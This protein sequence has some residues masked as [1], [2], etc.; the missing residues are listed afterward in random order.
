MEVISKLRLIEPVALEGVR[1][2]R[3]SSHLFKESIIK[4]T[5]FLVALSI[6]LAASSAFAEGAE[7]FI[8]QN[9]TTVTSGAVSRAQVQQD[10]VAAQRSGEL[11][12]IGAEAGYD[13]TAPHAVGAR[14]RAEVQ[15]EA[16]AL[17]HSPNQNLDP[18]AFVNSQIP[19]SLSTS[20]TPARASADAAQVSR[21]MQ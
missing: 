19:S 3:V 1:S 13:M 9:R 4:T 18:K 15:A 16:V 2:I 10:L 12:S 17:A 8:L 14:S 20:G 5:S 6:S 21:S 7:D 11:A